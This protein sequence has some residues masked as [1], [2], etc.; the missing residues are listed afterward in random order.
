MKN[1]EKLSNHQ[2]SPQQQQQQ[3]QQPKKKTLYVGK[4][5]K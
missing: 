2:P 4:W 3:Q 1:D 5:T